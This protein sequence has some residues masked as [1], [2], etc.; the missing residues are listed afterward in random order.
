MI[1]RFQVRPPTRSRA[2]STTTERPAAAIARAAVRPARPAPTTTTSAVFGTVEAAGAELDGSASSGD[3][4][5]ATLGRAAAAA[6]PAAVPISVRLV[7]PLSLPSLTSGHCL[8][9]RTCAL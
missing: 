4:A 3:S 1:G 6:A 7:N 9:K 2:S 5:R 8:T